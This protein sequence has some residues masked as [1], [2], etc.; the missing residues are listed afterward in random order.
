MARVAESREDGK[1]LEKRKYYAVIF[2]YMEKMEINL[3]L[4]RKLLQIVH[5]EISDLNI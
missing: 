2:L 5:I 3:N 1:L 4:V